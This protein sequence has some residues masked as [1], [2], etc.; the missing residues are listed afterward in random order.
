MRKFLQ[1]CMIGAC[2]LCCAGMQLWASGGKDSSAMMNSKDVV[3][4]KWYMSL[5]PIAPDTAKVI[6]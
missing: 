5:N 6:E 1:A 2:V 4:L 3:T